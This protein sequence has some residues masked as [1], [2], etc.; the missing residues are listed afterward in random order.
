MWVNS[1][2]E[3]DA[4]D[5]DGVSKLDGGG[6]SPGEIAWVILGKVEQSA[7]VTVCDVVGFGNFSQC[8]FLLSPHLRFVLV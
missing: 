7:M 3:L 2:V 1:I 6:S 5:I 4:K 8:L